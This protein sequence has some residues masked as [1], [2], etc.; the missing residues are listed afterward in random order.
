[1]DSVDNCFGLTQWISSYF[2]ELNACEDWNGL[3]WNSELTIKSSESDHK[4]ANML[5][6]KILHK[7]N[8]SHSMSYVTYVGML[9]TMKFFFI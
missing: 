5:E 2:I 4:L 8:R 6:F 3:I 1:M 9:L 7:K